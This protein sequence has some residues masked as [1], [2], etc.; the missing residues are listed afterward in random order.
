MHSTYK[1]MGQENMKKLNDKR[2]NNLMWER[3]R[4]F[5]CAETAKHTHSFLLHFSS[6]RFFFSWLIIIFRS[7]IILNTA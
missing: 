5:V 7:Y 3:L 2:T 6:S 4:S 1:C